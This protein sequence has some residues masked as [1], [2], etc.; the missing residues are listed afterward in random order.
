MSEM[1]RFADNINIAWQPTT[2]DGKVDFRFNSYLLDSIGN[3]TDFIDPKQ[4]NVRSE[5]INNVAQREIA[6]G[7]VDPITQETLPAL[8]GAGVIMLIKAVVEQVR[9]EMNNEILVNQNPPSET[10]STVTIEPSTVP[11]DETEATITAQLKTDDGN[12]IEW[13]G[14]DITFF[15][16]LGELVGENYDNGDG[17][18]TQNI[19]SLES[20]TGEVS[21]ILNDVETI[22]TT[23]VDFS[24]AAT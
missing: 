12:L 18:Y 6:A 21:V 22:T 9:Q 17:T 7:L 11:A 1:K 20:G 3:T 15:T 24:E 14:Y 10:H 4:Q 16:T 5:K 23:T 8:S 19:K 2:D 13:G